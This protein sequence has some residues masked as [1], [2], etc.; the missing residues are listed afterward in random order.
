MGGPRR[1]EGRPELTRA[2]RQRGL[3]QGAAAEAVGVGPTTWARWEPS[4]SDWCDTKGQTNLA[5]HE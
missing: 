5:W 3:S 1:G 4:L 2:R